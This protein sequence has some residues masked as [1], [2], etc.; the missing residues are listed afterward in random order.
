MRYSELEADFG[1]VHGDLVLETPLPLI[2]RAA[3]EMYT[4]EIFML[5][6]PVLRRVC[7]CT[8]V[9]SR[10]IVSLYFYTVM[11]YPKEHAE[12]QV[13]FCPTSL[14]F[15]CSCQRL[16]SLGIVCEHVV[17]VLV[18]LNI[19]MLPECLVINRWTKHAK[20][21]I[22]VCNPKT[23][24]SI[25]STT[26]S[27]FTNVVERCKRMVVAVVKC[28][29]P[30]LMRST[31]DLVDAQTKLLEDECNNNE[32]GYVYN[33]TFFEETI[34]N[35]S[36]VRTKGCG[37]ATTSSSQSRNKVQRRRYDCE[38]MSGFQRRNIG[39]R[40]KPQTCGVCAIEGH[41]RTSCP[42]L[43]QNPISSELGVDCDAVN[44]EDGGDHE[45][46]RNIGTVEMNV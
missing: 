27:K 44:N 37:V 29:K 14:Q 26:V 39:K 7:T 8:V 4:R 18:Y 43:S 11:K 6:Q 34:L 36:R 12:W 2:E 28:G 22:A 9:D 38:S 46:Y 45:E 35:P 30:Q 41:N 5:F 20:D 3:G 19:V 10:Q 31:L 17:A 13:S 40:R 25:E 1:S 32:P 15:K 21:A 16:E 24:L 33:Q 23:N 42:I